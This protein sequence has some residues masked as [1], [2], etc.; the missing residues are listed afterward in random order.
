MSCQGQCIWKKKESR[1]KNARF[2]QIPIFLGSLN[3]CRVKFLNISGLMWHLRGSSYFFWERTTH[4]RVK[5]I[6]WTVLQRYQKII[7]FNW[8]RFHI[9]GILNPKILVIFGSKLVEI[10]QAKSGYQ[11]GHYTSYTWSSKPLPLVFQTPCVSRWANPQTPPDKV[12]RGSKLL[13]RRYLE[14]FG[15]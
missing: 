15:D 5:N 1:K 14:D 13:L 3:I 10:S 7:S 2:F 4:W 11:V 6:T 8:C 12:F 9:F